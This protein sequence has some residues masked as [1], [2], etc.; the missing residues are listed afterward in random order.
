MTNPWDQ[1]PAGDDETQIV[2]PPPQV[3]YP[4]PPGYPA[5]PSYPGAPGYPGSPG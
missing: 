2:T 3:D 1:Q 5:P 4:A